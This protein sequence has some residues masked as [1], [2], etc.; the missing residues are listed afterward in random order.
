MIGAPLENGED[1]LQRDKGVVYVFT[2]T[3]TAWTEQPTLLR[4][5]NGEGGTTPQ[6]PGDNS[7]AVALSADGVTLVVGAPLEDGSLHQPGENE[8]DAAPDA[9]AAYVFVRNGATYELQTYLK[10][11]PDTF[12][13]LIAGDRFGS[14]SLLQLTARR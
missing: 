3:G 8:N 13:S 9:G 14:S 5:P 2:R 10:P 11:R 12:D 4:A 6:V 7:V 1:G